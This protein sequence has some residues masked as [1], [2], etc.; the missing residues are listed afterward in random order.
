M[1]MGFY[2]CRSVGCGVKNT[3]FF[4]SASLFHIIFTTAI[5]VC[6]A[7]HCNSI[8]QHAKRIFYQFGLKLIFIH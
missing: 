7:F 1:K 5:T 4:P 6:D 2:Q 8:H 3:F